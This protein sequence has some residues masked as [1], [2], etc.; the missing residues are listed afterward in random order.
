MTGYNGNFNVMKSNNKFYSEKSISDKDGFLQITIPPGAYE[1]ESINNE[2]KRI[3]FDEGLFPEANYPF[4][5]K[6]NFSTIASIIEISPARPVFSFKSDDSIRDLL[7]FHAIN[8]YEEYYLSPNTIDLLSFDSV[9]LETD[10]AQGLIFKGR[11]SGIIHKF[12]K[13]VDP[14]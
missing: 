14:R 4:T 12:I 7:G 6:P 11:T 1:I 9:F 3:I 5:I 10:I 13:D 2:T 8:L